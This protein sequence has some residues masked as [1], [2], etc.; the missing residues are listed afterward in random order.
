M[1]EVWWSRSES[2][3]GASV[4][5]GCSR[6]CF[7][8]DVSRKLHP[9]LRVEQ[10]FAFC[11]KTGAAEKQ[12]G[13]AEARGLDTQNHRSSQGIR[14]CHNQACSGRWKTDHRPGGGKKYVAK[15]PLLQVDQRNVQ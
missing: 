5:R 6:N 2:E 14:L 10:V 13:T 11:E 4:I 7:V 3:K 9:H 12:R 8:I 15:G 1:V